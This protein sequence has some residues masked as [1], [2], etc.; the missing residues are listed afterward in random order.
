MSRY[1]GATFRPIRENSTEPTIMPTQLILHSAVTRA[2]SLWAFFQRSDVVVESH[3]YVQHDGDCEQYIDT[4]RQADANYKA[5]VR[6]VSVETW[7]G[8][9]PDHIPWNE[10]QLA[11]MVDIAV[12]MHRTHKMP[13]RMAPRWDAPGIGGHTLYPSYW[14]NV[15]GKTCPGL[16]RRQQVAVIISRA[17]ARVAAPIIKPGPVAKP[18]VGVKAPRFPLPAGYYF[19]PKDGPKESV[20]GYFSHSADFGTFQNQMIR[21]GWR[22]M[23]SDGRYDVPADRDIIIAFQKEKH[24]VAD[25]HVGPATWNAAWTAAVT[26]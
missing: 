25:G 21:R 4:N 16:A 20:S 10:P 12:F 24:L 18:V 5:N 26:K 7:D 14:T 17:R 19:G 15:R 8:G 23:K 6:A 1:P 11:R 13:L 2:D 9:D 22:A 3:M